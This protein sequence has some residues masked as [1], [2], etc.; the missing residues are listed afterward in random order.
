MKTTNSKRTSP[1]PDLRALSSILRQYTGS[2]GIDEEHLIDLITD[3]G[4]YAGRVLRADPELILATAQ[5]HLEVELP[6][7][8]LPGRHTSPPRR[9][10]PGHGTT[11]HR[12]PRGTTTSS[13]ACGRRR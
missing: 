10:N 8:N 2:D 6:G 5:R 11:R 9:H 3:L 4:H 7:G 12:A 13:G 1:G